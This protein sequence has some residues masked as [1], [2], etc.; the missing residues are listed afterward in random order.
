MNDFPDLIIRW[1]LGENKVRTTSLQAYDML[2]CSILF[3]KK[4]FKKQILFC[5]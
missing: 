4:I 3:A 2:Y 5:M 1:T